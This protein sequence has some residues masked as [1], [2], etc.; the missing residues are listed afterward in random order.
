[1]LSQ[2]YPPFIGG[3]ER[4]VQILGTELSKRGHE[5]AVATVWKKDTPEYEIDQGVRIY[6][7]KT[8]VQRATWLFADPA[9]SH[10]PPFPDPEAVRA[11]KCIIA[12]ER[13]HIVHAHN[14]LVYSFLPLKTWSDAKLVLSL[15]DYSRACATKKLLYRDTSLCSGPGVR[16]CLDCS[17]H[18]YGAAKG[19]S[20]AVEIPL[21]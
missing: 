3:E 19:I 20:T 6:R 9:H 14:W 4:S 5:V 16:K 11:L 8:T 2:F 7:F 12:Q 15:H 10:A 21:A 13:P 17:M 1:M 18:H